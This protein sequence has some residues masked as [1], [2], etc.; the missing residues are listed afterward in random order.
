MQSIELTKTWPP[1]LLLDCEL[2]GSKYR[3]NFTIVNFGVVVISAEL[4]NQNKL[5]IE[6]M[7]LGEI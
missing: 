7:L 1:D 5:L 4:G 3:W 2:C 6:V